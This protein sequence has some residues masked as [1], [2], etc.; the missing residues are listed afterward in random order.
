MYECVVDGVDGEHSKAVNITGE[1][2]SRFPLFVC[3]ILHLFVSC[4]EEIESKSTEPLTEIVFK[5]V[6]TDLAHEEAIRTNEIVDFR[7]DNRHTTVQ[8]DASKNYIQKNSFASDHKV[9]VANHSFDNNDRS[10]LVLSEF[11]V[12]VL[13]TGAGRLCPKFFS[14]VESNSASFPTSSV[15]LMIMCS[16][17]MLCN[18]SL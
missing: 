2:S 9:L 16:L 14:L 5:S 8:T 3:L 4:F 13:P 11:R 12:I 10:M 18:R 15:I 1:S 17:A 6:Q 7:I